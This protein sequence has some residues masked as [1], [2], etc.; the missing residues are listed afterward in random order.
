VAF[1]GFDG[2]TFTT[3]P[4]AGVIFVTLKPFEERLKA[5]STQRESS[6]VF[7]RKCRRCVRPSCSQYRRRPS[8]VLEL[9]V[10]SKCMCRIAPA[11]AREPLNKRSAQFW[12]LHIVQYVDA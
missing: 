5:G 6:M 4:N 11:V 7:V 2:A 3:A 8:Q 1:A 12:V 10:V 9:V